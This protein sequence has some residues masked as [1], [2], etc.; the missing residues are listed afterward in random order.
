LE[1]ALAR[2]LQ[3]AHYAGADLALQA[4]VLAQGLAETQPFIEGNK[5]VALA[6]M[7]AF[8]LANGLDLTASQAERAAWMLELSRTLTADELAAKIRESLVGVAGDDSS[9]EP[10]TLALPWAS[11]LENEPLPD[12]GAWAGVAWRAAEESPPEKG[13]YDRCGQCGMLL[14]HDF[15]GPQAREPCPRCGGMTRNYSRSV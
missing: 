8:L 11:Q 1:G 13:N 6:G 5:R 9:P 10:S 12:E 4:A 3:H 14:P 2:P 15:S 7:R